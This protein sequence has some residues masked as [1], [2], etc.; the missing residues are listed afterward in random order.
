MKGLIAE[1]DA[2]AE[3]REMRQ[4]MVSGIEK[5]STEQKSHNSIWDSIF[6]KKGLITGG[7]LMLAPIILKFLNKFL[8]L[9]LGSILSN[10]GT[11]GRQCSQQTG[12]SVFRIPIL[13]KKLRTEGRVRRSP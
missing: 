2:A 11:S 13:H 8:G 9:D 6:S 7:L 10:I 3:E 5:I 12:R 4:R 1:A